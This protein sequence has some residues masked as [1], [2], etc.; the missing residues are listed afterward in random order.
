MIESMRVKS[1]KAHIRETFL[2]ILGSYEFESIT[3]KQLA[4][5]ASVNRSTIYDHYDSLL[6]ILGDCIYH[7]AGRADQQIPSS[8]DPNFMCNLKSVIAVSC[9]D[10]RDNCDLYLFSKRYLNKIPIDAQHIA[11][12]KSHSD[13]FYK[14][15]VEA[16]FQIHPHLAIKSEYLERMLSCISLASIEGWRTSGF[17][18]EP[19]DVADITI[20]AFEGIIA[21]FN[22]S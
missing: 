11:I 15:V 17:K 1:T 6:S 14:G 9:R 13:L 12:V 8:D 4:E 21:A 2:Q 10:I 16:L 20:K 18:E 3:I 7:I 22:N 5:A 19:E